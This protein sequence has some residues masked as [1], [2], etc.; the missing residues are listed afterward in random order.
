M[1]YEPK[2]LNI[3]AWT[4][5]QSLCGPGGGCT[6]L[7]LCPLETT[8]KVVAAKTFYKLLKLQK[9]GR[10]EMAQEEEFGEIGVGLAEA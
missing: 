8:V 5:L 3:H 7:Q 9:E 4:R 1:V 2:I 6:F 10:L